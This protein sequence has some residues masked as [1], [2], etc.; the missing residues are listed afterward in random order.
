MI[1]S[2]YIDDV[3]A[4]EDNI[5]RFSLTMF[6]VEERGYHPF[7]DLTTINIT[8]SLRWFQNIMT[9]VDIILLRV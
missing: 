6:E 5:L 9:H 8:L 4:S 2:L 7:P 3:F 1:V